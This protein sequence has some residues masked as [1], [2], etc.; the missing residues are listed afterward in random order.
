VRLVE[1]ARQPQCGDRRRLG[2]DREVGEDVPHEGLS[3]RS[4]PKAARWEA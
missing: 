4:F 2:L 1:G 3:T